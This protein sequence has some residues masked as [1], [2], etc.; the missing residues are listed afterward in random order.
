MSIVH[1]ITERKRMEDERINSKLTQQ[2]AILNAIL[3][4]QEA[5]RKRI[6]EALHNGLGQLLYATKLQLG[7][8]HPEK[9]LEKELQ[10]SIDNLLNE[11]IKETRQLS[12]ELMPSI[13]RDFGLEAAIEEIC[14][15]VSSSKIQ[16]QCEVLGLKDRLDEIL[17]TAIFRICQELLNNIIKHSQA[18]EASI[19]LLN[20]K[21]KIV[22]RVEDNGIGFDPEKLDRTG[23]GLSSI[24]NRLQLIDGTLDIESEPG[25]GSLFTIKINKN[26]LK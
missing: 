16:L 17:E 23:L 20:Q 18:T 24:R 25:Q 22:L 14:K 4:T 9:P 1:D 2:K 26:K 3:D 8:M 15:R 11:A 6:S 7:D 10:T 21:T 19:Q 13:L 5:E 12:F